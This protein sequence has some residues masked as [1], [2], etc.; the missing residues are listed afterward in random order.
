MK[1]G[2]IGSG[3]REHALCES[4]KKSDKIEK[5]Y[6]DKEKVKILLGPPDFIDR[7]KAGEDWYYSHIRST[8]YAL[9]SFPTSGHLVNH[10][11]YVKR[12]EWK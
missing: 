6:S 1:V 2:I 9:V 8:G 7:H 3:G 4:L 5:I 11:Q 12:P 10:V